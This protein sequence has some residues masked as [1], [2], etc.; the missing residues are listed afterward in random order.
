MLKIWI[1]EC[2]NCGKEINGITEHFYIVDENTGF[3]HL[4][5]RCYEEVL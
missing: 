5:D 2:D 3:E 4:C 1:I